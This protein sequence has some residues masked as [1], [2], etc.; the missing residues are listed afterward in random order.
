MNFM[1]YNIYI[2]R[3]REVK[4]EITRLDSKLD[5]VLLVRRLEHRERDRY[6]PF[7][8]SWLT[9]ISALNCHHRMLLF[10]PVP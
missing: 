7:V 5:S 1:Y 6:L 9:F 2:Y 8:I 10:P 4:G 3:A